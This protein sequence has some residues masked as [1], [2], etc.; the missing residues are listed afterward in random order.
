M[1]GA[2][3]RILPPSFTGSGA[4]PLGAL[5]MLLSCLGAP[6]AVVSIRGEPQVMDPKSAH[7]AA[8]MNAQ[9]VANAASSEIE[10]NVKLGVGELVA[11]VKK[12][13]MKHHAAL[14]PPETGVMDVDQALYMLKQTEAEHD[15]K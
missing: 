3:E 2:R 12:M 6:A 13:L 4:A 9:A 8:Q 10:K 1:G 15:E 14:P 5:L 7:A 11:N